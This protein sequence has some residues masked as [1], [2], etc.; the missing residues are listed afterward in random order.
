MAKRIPTTT[1]ITVINKK[2]ANSKKHLSEKTNTILFRTK[3]YYQ[4]VS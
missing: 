4:K 3:Q 2:K 1:S